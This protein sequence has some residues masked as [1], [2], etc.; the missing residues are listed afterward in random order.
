ML[1]FSLAKVAAGV[2]LTLALLAGVWKIHHEGVRAGRTEIQS[3]WNADKAQIAEQNKTKLKEA[4]NVTA[5]LQKKLDTERGVLNARIHSIDLERSEL[6]QRLR[7]RPT[8]TDQSSN[9]SAPIADAGKSAPSCTGAELYREDGE[10]LVREASRAEVL[11]AAIKT[12]ESA[13]S[14][15][16]E[17]IESLRK[18]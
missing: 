2:V 8:R 11:R 5:A 3:L 9:S 16:Q 14:N 6:L 17:L 15:A 4:N 13:Y 18:K 1:P 7:N 10:F 12:C